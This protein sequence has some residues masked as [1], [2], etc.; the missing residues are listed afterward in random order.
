MRQPYAITVVLL[1]FLATSLQ[2]SAAISS[3]PQLPIQVMIAPAQQGVTAETMRPGDVVELA[4]TATAQTEIAEMRIEAKL[5]AGAELVSGSLTWSG[6]AAKGE[7]KLVLFSVRVPDQGT[8]KIRATVTFFRDGKKMMKRSVLYF[9]GVD[10]DEKEKKPAY[11]LKKDAK[12]RDIIE[13]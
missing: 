1:L 13:Y 6:P 2:A 11:K 4:V 12:G 9:L 8:G 7:P 10:R 5:Q 3:K